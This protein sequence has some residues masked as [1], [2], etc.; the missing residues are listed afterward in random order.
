MQPPRTRLTVALLI[1]FPFCLAAIWQTYPPHE[2]DGFLPN[3][4][5]QAVTDVRFSI[6]AP[7]VLYSVGA[8]GMLIAS[9]LQTGQSQESDQ[10]RRVA[11]GLALTLLALHDS[12]GERLVRY[13]AHY[14]VANG[15]AVTAASGRELIATCG[16]DGTV[17]VFDPSI[18]DSKE[19]VA[20]LDDGL[21]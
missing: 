7:D 1:D 18:E 16:D 2:N 13:P 12:A 15:L 9:D 5:K 19:P 4:H 3:V 11:S 21:E 14:G 6:D 20:E 10:I 17:R 8:D